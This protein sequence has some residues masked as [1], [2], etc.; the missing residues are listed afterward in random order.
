MDCHWNWNGFLSALPRFELCYFFCLEPSAA[1]VARVAQDSRNPLD[2]RASGLLRRCVLFY[3]LP[4][5][6]ILEDWVFT[7]A[8]LVLSVCFYPF[9]EELPVIEN[10]LP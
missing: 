6:N 3:I 5:Q 7:S 9:T 1:I 10:N 2:I 8:F 4:S